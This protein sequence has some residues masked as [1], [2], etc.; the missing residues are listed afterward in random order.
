[1]NLFENENIAYLSL[2]INDLFKGETLE[3]LARSTGFI[4]RSSSRLSGRS[5]VLLNVLDGSID[6]D[7]SLQDTCNNLE[8]HFGIKLTKQSLDERYN[9]FSVS[10]MRAVY[11]NCLRSM[12]QRQSMLQ[13]RCFFQK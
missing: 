6:Q 11:E 12:T 3:A 9:T 2:K 7:W 10:F 5:F 1:M 13:L 4:E 8:S